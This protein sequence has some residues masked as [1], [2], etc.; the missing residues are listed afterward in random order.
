MEGVPGP[1]LPGA[2]PHAQEVGL[3]AAPPV[4]CPAQLCIV[5]TSGLYV[6]IGKSMFTILQSLAAFLCLMQLFKVFFPDIEDVSN[7][8]SKWILDCI[9]LEH[10]HLLQGR[11][12][13]G[14]LCKVS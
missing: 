14:A 11:R 13:G 8:L 10:F 9:I 2:G 4:L 5:R 12:D 1:G 7:G 3:L 6:N